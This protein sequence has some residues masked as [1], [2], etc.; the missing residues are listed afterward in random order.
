MLR[1]HYALPHLRVLW[2][3][4]SLDGSVLWPGMGKSRVEANFSQEK[5]GAR[6]SSAQALA[7]R[8]NQ[9]QV[10]NIRFF[11]KIGVFFFV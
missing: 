8:K 2:N 6:D 1:F 3:E 4:P 9:S 10:Q 11:Q 5:T 7:A